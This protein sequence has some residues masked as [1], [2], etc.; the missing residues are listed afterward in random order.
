MKLNLTKNLEPAKAVKLAQIDAE[1]NRALESYRTSGNVAA[2]VYKLKRDEVSEADA[3]R[4]IA[5]LSMLQAEARATGIAPETL[6][7]IWRKK[8][9]EEN[10]FLIITESARQALKARVKNATTPAELDTINWS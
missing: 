4:P 8:V 5:E 6:I 7:G 1:A 2:L 10:L 3:G 9:A